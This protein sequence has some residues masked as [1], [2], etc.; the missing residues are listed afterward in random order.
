[1]I[2]D[3][4]RRYLERGDLQ[5]ELLGRGFTWFDTGTYGSLVEAAAFFQAIERRQG[6]R[7]AVPEE[8]AL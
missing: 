6:Q 2:T 8:I 3:F 4:N 5:V 1:M 7:I